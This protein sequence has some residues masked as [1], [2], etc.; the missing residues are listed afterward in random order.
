ML[1]YYRLTRLQNFLNKS[2]WT[3]SDVMGLKEQ[4]PPDTYKILAREAA[5]REKDAIWHYLQKTLPRCPISILKVN[6]SSFRN[7]WLTKSITPTQLIEIL[8]DLNIE[9]KGKYQW[10]YNTV[11]KTLDPEHAAYA[12]LRQNMWT[13]V[14]DVK[15]KIDALKDLPAVERKIC[16]LSR[17]IWLRPYNTTPFDFLQIFQRRQY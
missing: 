8:Q 5:L 4:L 15:A 1:I 12:T 3:F 13:M 10:L 11:T 9:H 7:I 14:K 17:N 6:L 2:N 16:S